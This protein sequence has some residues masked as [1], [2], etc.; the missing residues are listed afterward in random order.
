MRLLL[1]HDPGAN[2]FSRQAFGAAA[3][4]LGLEVVEGTAG[5]PL[6]ELP[7]HPPLL[8]YRSGKSTAARTLEAQAQRRF[9]CVTLDDPADRPADRDAAM[10]AA[11]VPAPP[12]V[13]VPS[14]APGALA[15]AV[16]ALGGFPII[17]KQPG[18]N[19][20]G[21]IRV[22]DMSTLNGVARLLGVEE[23][24]LRLRAYIHHEVQ[25]RVFVLRGRVI[26]AV[27]FTPA[28]NEFRTNRSHRRGMSREP[29]PAHLARIAVQA[30]AAVG[31]GFGGVDI[32]ID[33]EGRP[34]VTE[35]NSPC[36][37]QRTVKAFGSPIALEVLRALL[38]VAAG[39]APQGPPPPPATA[40]ELP[41]LLAVVCAHVSATAQA[42]AA[43]AERRGIP[44]VF[45]DDEDPAPVLLAAERTWLF[46]QGEAGEIGTGE[47]SRHPGVRTLRGATQDAQEALGA[48]GLP[49]VRQVEVHHFDPVLLDVLTARLGGLPLAARILLNDREVA[50]ACA[51]PHDLRSLIDYALAWDGRVRL[52]APIEAAAWGRL[53]VLDGEIV[54]ALRHE[55]AG[56]GC[57]GLDPPRWAQRW[58]PPAEHADLAVRAAAATG[59]RFARVDLALYQG[60]SAKVERVHPS[61]DLALFHRLCGVDLAD[62]ALAALRGEPATPPTVGVAPRP[63]APGDPMAPWGVA[64]RRLQLPIHS[65]SP[66]HEPQE[67]HLAIGAGLIRVS[68]GA[69]S[70][71]DA[72]AL[73]LAE[74]RPAAWVALAGAGL[75]VCRQVVVGEPRDPVAFRLRFPLVARGLG[76]GRDRPPVGGLRDPLALGA[77]WRA[78]TAQGTDLMVVEEQA[79]GVQL[80]M[81]LLDGAL[82]HALLLQ[83][84]KVVGDGERS[85]RLLLEAENADRAGQDRPSIPIDADLRNALKNQELSLGATPT[86]GR[87]VQLQGI[88]SPERGAFLQGLGQAVHPG[89]TRL[90]QEAAAT[91]RLTL[92]EVELVVQD[93]DA[94]PEAQGCRI[95]G[96]SG[97]P[98]LI[99]HLRPTVGRGAD[100]AMEIL[101]SLHNGAR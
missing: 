44:T 73:L 8:L 98:D 15:R 45:I 20:V 37:F 95:S 69:P 93:A 12:T 11:G 85:L 58:R 39:A 51:H 41:E 4:E 62:R 76:D 57:P 97:R 40:V 86:R 96:V 2:R 101:G 78:L 31:V 54:A 90:A 55:A 9:Q 10:L 56:L 68:R 60:G 32:L 28:P 52:H 49:F 25:H 35:V 6:P 47:L 30:A 63:L 65:W 50:V 81:V 5:R 92:A 19:S 18:Q 66:R 1:I 27:Q 64:A 23:R 79:P 43:A 3:T 21:V 17:V 24:P 84:A 70:L 74:D 88:A 59:H 46:Q 38:E 67:T 80:R 42:L 82:L 89:L 16:E 72:A 14:I 22:G 94:P 75:P 7:A 36:S 48:A 53:V 87:V 100:L 91:L 29:L 99:S 13:R 71:N 34:W 77:A 83:P 26:E 33:Q 61:F